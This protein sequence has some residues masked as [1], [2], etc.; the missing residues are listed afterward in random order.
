MIVKKVRAKV[1]DNSRKE[2]T[3][4]V[5]IK[6]SN[7]N[8]EASA[9]SG[10]STSS[11]EAVAFPLGA[12]KSADLINK[13]SFKDI[14]INSFEDL[15]KIEALFNVNEIGGNGF[16]AL[17]AAVLKALSKGKVWQF[18]DSKA[19]Q[20]PRPLGNC[21]GGGKHIKGKAACDF[22]EFL[23]FS[24]DAPR[25]NSAIL[26]NT[27]LYEFMG[28]K[29]NS[30]DE[31]FHKEITD[32]GAWSPN[33]SNLEILDAL[34][35]AVEK[36]NARIDFKVSIGIDVAASSFFDGKH[37]VYKNFSRDEK[38]KKLTKKEHLALL[39]M[40]VKKYKVAY[41]E[42]PVEENDF[43]GFAQLTKKVGKMCLIVGDD[44]TATHPERLAKA[45]KGKCINATIIKPNQAGSY[46]KMREAILL[47]QK[48]NIH[49][50]M[51]HR[52][53]ETND[54]I[55]SDLAVG[56]HC[57]LIKCGIFGAERVAK[58]ERVKA[59]ENE[60]RALK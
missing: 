8:Y 60:I 43:D 42:D 40:I 27:E 52:S 6:T 30:W 46:L 3:L 57:P 25:V 13:H 11:F 20:V 7:G 16:I 56:F 29:L 35:N 53:G 31:T 38:E 47:A 21:I 2:K 36:I 15:K 55:L 39:E 32:E 28:K 23:L 9:P 4:K 18:L 1:I 44:L 24:L 26:A 10:A 37:Y 48:N 14:E 41:L 54:N 34:F 49:C 17:E 58:L 12:K 59:I 33:L 45:I 19:K 22:Q 50:I 5:I 51:S